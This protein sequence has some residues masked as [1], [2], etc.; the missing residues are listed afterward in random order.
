MSAPVARAGAENGPSKP[1]ADAENAPKMME[2]DPEFSSLVVIA[3]NELRKMSF[4]HY[5]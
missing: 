4:G 1:S 2:A 5:P 3:I